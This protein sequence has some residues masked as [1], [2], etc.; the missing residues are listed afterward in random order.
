MATIRTHMCTAVRHLLLSGFVLLG[1]A[2][3]TQA[4]SLTVSFSGIIDLTGTGGPANSPFSGFFTWDPAAS[5]FQS[6]P[7]NA[8]IYFVES[9]Q[10]IL[11]GVDRTLPPGEAGLEVSNDSDL[12]SEPG[13]YDGLLFLAGLDEDV[14]IGGVNGDTIFVLAFLGDKASWNTLALPSDYAFLTLFPD[15]FS[16]VSLE[17]NGPGDDVVV[18]EGGAFT[19]TPAAVPEPATLTL[20]GLGLVGVLTRARRARQRRNQ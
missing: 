3:N 19:A 20:T 14:T 17:R 13:D 2:S 15:R 9:Y 16:A 4:A 6:D 18:G 10:L 11:N 5:P 7:P 8:A 12:N 1:V